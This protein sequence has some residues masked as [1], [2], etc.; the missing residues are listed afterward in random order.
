MQQLRPEDR[1]LAHPIWVHGDE[2]KGKRERSLFLLSWGTLGI[3]PTSDIMMF[4][5]PYVDPGH[6]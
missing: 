1:A 6:A 5:F 2:G 3:R 4:R